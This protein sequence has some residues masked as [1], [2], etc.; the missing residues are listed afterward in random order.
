MTLIQVKPALLTDE[1]FAL[2]KRTYVSTRT[3]SRVVS[4]CKRCGREIPKGAIR[5]GAFAIRTP[6]SVPIVRGYV[7]GEC[8]HGE[9]KR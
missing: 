4:V 9:E 5:R 3:A 2:V 1:Q 8:L 6:D 7:C